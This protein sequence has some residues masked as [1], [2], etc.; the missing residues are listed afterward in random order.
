M[1]IDTS[2]HQLLILADRLLPVLAASSF[3]VALGV[4]TGWSSALL[5]LDDDFLFFAGGLESSFDSA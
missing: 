5:D 2:V 4:V 1:L 3:L